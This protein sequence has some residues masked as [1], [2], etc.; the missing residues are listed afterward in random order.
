MKKIATLVLISL[1]FLFAAQAIAQ[2]LIAVQNGNTPRFFQQVDDA[3]VN[4]VDGDTLYIPGGSWNLTQHINKRLHL[5]GV[6]HY[7]DSTKATFPTKINSQFILDS[8]ASNGSITGINILGQLVVQTDVNYYTVKRCR[9]SGVFIYTKS[10]NFSFMENVLDGG[11]LVANNVV[12]S[13]F[14]FFNNIISV[15]FSYSFDNA[16][17]SCINSIFKNNIFLLNSYCSWG[18][19]T[20]SVAAYFSLFENNVFLNTGSLGG[21]YYSTLRNNIF[22]E[23]FSFD[24][25]TKVGSNNL[26]G[27]PQAGIFVNQSGNTFDYSHDYHLQPNSPGKNAGT[28][29]TDIGIYGGMFPWKE[30]SIPSNPHFQSIQIAPKTDTNGNLNVK[31]K[32]AA[33]DH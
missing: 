30:G 2:N 20:F 27:Q 32:V 15:N 21:V 25:T 18:S 28:D 7:P 31:I 26:F 6:G 22:V 10:S 23:G 9:I 14:T 5:I 3:I 19:C 29:G 13:N 12:A 4:A 17:F 16:N 11:S 1:L 33:Q 24:N 8:G